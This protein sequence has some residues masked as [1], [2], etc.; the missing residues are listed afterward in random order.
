MITN[1]SK[2]QISKGRKPTQNNVKVVNGS[3]TIN[4]ILKKQMSGVSL[5]K[6]G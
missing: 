1:I 6:V 3:D 4:T 2:E 5:P